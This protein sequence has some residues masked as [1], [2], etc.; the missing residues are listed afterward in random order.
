MFKK[1]QAKMK[2]KKGFTL[3]ELLIVIAVL[4]IIAAIAVPRFTGVLSGVTAK[5][6]VRTAELFA[7]EIEAEFM[8]ETWSFGTATTLAVA[9]PAT[10]AAATTG[11]NGNIPQD[12]ANGAMEATITRSGTAGAYTYTL[13]I[14]NSASTAVILLPSKAISGPIS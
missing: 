8:L 5:A 7:K 14:T 1:I 13:V 9:P 2:N 11:F 12:S 10:S 6:D 3:V 4:G